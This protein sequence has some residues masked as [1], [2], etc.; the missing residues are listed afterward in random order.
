MKKRLLVLL[1]G[2][3][4]I[5]VVNGADSETQ[6]NFTIFGCDFG[7]TGLPVGNC[8][9]EGNY[10]CSY[11]KGNYILYD[12]VYDYTGCSYGAAVY[13]AGYPFCCPIGYFCENSAEGPICNLREGQCSDQ[14]TQ[15]DCEDMGCYWL[16]VDEGICIKIPSDYSCSIYQTFETCIEDG[17]RLGQNG[18]GTG[19]CGTYYI[20]DNIEYLR[21]N[22]R[23]NW[24]TSCK[25][26]WDS[27][28]EFN[29]GTKNSFKCL[30]SFDMDP[31]V[32]G[33]QLITWN[34]TSQIISGYSSGIPISVLEASG[35]ISNSEGVERACGLP[36]LKLLGFSLLSFFISLG[37]IGLFYFLKELKNQRD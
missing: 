22:C 6:S 21:K 30:K 10:F 23:C 37:V 12:T 28:E 32:N 2:I 8:S 13:T 36:T 3:F 7:E 1:I 35:C 25:L 19:I 34:A 27:V 17:L 29:N 9:P 4:I 31:C 20:A 14:L 5:G 15:S 18:D 24:D 16:L 26:V 33:T 11:E